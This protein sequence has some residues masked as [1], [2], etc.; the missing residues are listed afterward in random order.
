MQS[1][2][3]LIFVVGAICLKF[4]HFLSSGEEEG[5]GESKLLSV[6]PSPGKRPQLQGVGGRGREGGVLGGGEGGGKFI[7]A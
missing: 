6:L 2:D 1:P 7:K 5:G 3:S 4:N